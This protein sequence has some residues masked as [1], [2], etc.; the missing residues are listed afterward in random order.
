[1]KAPALRSIL[2]RLSAKDA[3]EREKRIKEA[4]VAERARK[5]PEDPE[6][7]MPPYTPNPYPRSLLSR[8]L[9]LLRVP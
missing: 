6:G 9:F 4:V 2:K 3:R 1:V 5:A 8:L 7:L